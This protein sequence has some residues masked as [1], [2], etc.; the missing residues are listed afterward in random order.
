MIAGIHDPRPA[1]NRTIPAGSPW[2]WRFLGILA[3]LVLGASGWASGGAVDNEVSRG[4]LSTEQARRWRS[5]IRTALFVPD[6]LPRLAVENHGRFE[7]AVGVVAERVS[8]A[9]QFGMRVPAI[10]YSPRE[11]RRELPA[12]IIVNGH[13]G[14]KYCWY[15]FYS[16]I[17][18]ARA[19]AVVLTYDPHQRM[20]QSAGRNRGSA[21]CIRGTGRRC[22]STRCGRSRIVAIA[23]ECLH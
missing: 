12:L 15:A 6:P 9:T 17:L 22:T 13:G 23:V 10:V 14:D 18:Y 19:G 20:G 5:A 8:Y 2:P 21:L 11:D 4:G 1:E 7:P 16:G 3:S